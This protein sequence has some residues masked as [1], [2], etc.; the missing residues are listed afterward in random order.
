L[1]LYR[2]R[3]S[4]LLI[5]NPG[6]PLASI[7]LGEVESRGVE[8]DTSGRILPG[9]NVTFA[10]AYN[11]SSIIADAVYPI[12]NILQNAPRHSGSIWTVYEIQRGALR[13]LSFGGGIQARSYRYVDPSDDVVLPG[14]ARL[15]A[16][17]SYVFGPA[18]A[19][20]KRYRIAVNICEHSEPDEPPLL[21]WRKHASGYLP[22]FADQRDDGV[23][24]A[25]LKPVVID[26][27]SHSYCSTSWSIAWLSHR[28]A[29]AFLC[30]V[31]LYSVRGVAL[32]NRQYLS[33]QTPD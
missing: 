26:E 33:V 13:G 5:T 17:A 7:Q 23:S 12:G 1:A 27:F 16:T 25:L 18:H 2:I 20:Q 10:Y 28:L 29:L 9:W 30:W 22:R 15:D 24:S 11:Q 6:N 32:D 21:C 31:V 8:L 14:Y 4:N 19:D 3:S